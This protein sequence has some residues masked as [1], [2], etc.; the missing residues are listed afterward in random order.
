MFSGGAVATVGS[1]A[2]LA[3]DDSGSS[4][5]DADRRVDPRGDAA[6]ARRGI[7]GAKFEVFH[8]YPDREANGRE[9]RPILG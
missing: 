4:K 8:G 7:R 9:R 6:R 1:S 5:H 2:S 3:G